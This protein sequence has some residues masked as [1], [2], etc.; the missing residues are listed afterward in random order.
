MH[1]EL[2]NFE[3]KQVWEFVEPPS[4]CKTIETKWVWKNRGK[5]R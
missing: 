4:G 5:E 1:E 3:R 2:E